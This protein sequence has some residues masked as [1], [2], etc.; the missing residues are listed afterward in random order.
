MSKRDK[1][2]YQNY[3]ELPTVLWIFGIM[4]I[5]LSSL[6][7]STLLHD[8]ENLRMLFLTVG[9]LSGS[10]GLSIFIVA[11]LYPVVKGLI[12]LRKNDTDDESNI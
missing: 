12:V 8:I 5:S 4:G 9:I 6:I 7:L 3:T 10:M 11:I 2:L 1:E